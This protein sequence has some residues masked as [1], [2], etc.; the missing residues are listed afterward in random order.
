MSTLAI[1]VGFGVATLLSQWLLQGR[2][3]QTRAAQVAAIHLGIAAP[4][5]V[6]TRLGLHAGLAAPILFWIGAGLT[7]FVVRSHLE[8]SILLALLEDLDA[9]LRR[10]HE[11]HGLHARIG[12]LAAAGLIREVD[13][14]R[15]VTSKGRLVLACFGWLG[16]GAT[17]H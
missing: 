5:L 4:V 3:V 14:R 17:T 10:F 8:S 7:W 13:G 2:K 6:A 16:S 15:L 11:R 9:G 12:E 1:V